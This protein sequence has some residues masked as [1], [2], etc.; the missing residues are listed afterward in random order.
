MVFWRG[1]PDPDVEPVGLAA[2]ILG[3]WPKVIA[4]AITVVAAGLALAVTGTTGGGSRA[5]GTSLISGGLVSLAF[6]V[7]NAVRDSHNEQRRRADALRLQLS[8]SNE[9]PAID[10]SFADLHRA[11]LPSRNFKGSRL[12]GVAL[13]GCNLAGSDLSGCDLTGS[14]LTGAYLKDVNFAESNLSGALLHGAYLGGADLRK[15][16]LVDSDC[17]SAMMAEVNLSGAQLGGAVFRGAT[18]WGADLSGCTFQDT[19]FDGAQLAKA[20]I[21][22]PMFFDMVRFDSSTQW[23][24]DLDAGLRQLLEPGIP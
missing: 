21:N 19:V 7:V 20:T 18:M 9:F 8:S 23:P 16:D 17:T 4:G 12:R 11:Y 13:Y 6:V 15:A 5:V 3:P 22:R 24:D 10:L 1:Q 2:W 14:D